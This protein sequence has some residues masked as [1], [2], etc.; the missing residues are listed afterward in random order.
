MNTLQQ[1]VKQ[2]P[3]NVI[4]TS[5]Y[6]PRQCGLATY[7]K[8]LTNA[9]NLLNSHSLAEILTV[10]PSGEN[11][12][13]PWESKFKINHLD[14][15]D[16]VG[17]AEYVNRSHADLVSLQHEFGLF[18]GDYGEY[19]VY[20]AEA[21]KIPLVT[22]FHTVLGEPSEK[23]REIIQR[24]AKK[25]Q[26]IIVMMEQV[27]QKLVSIYKVPRE[28][29]VV[30]PHGVPDIPFNATSMQ[31]RKHKLADRIVLGNINLLDP[32]K[33]IEYALE[34][35]ALLAKKYSNVLYMVIGQ[36]H[37]DLIKKED[38]N[39]R[40]F[41]KKR[42]RELG[43]SH[44][45]RFINKYLSL[46][47]LINWLKVIDVYITPYLEPQQATSGA[48][49]YAIGAGRACV[50]TPY[51]YAKEVLEEGRGVLVPF[52]D[53]ESI[54]NAVT[55]LLEHPDKSKEMATRAYKFGR[56]M[57]WPNVAQSHL[58]L[59]HTILRKNDRPKKII[60]PYTLSGSLLPSGQ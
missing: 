25:S 44:N 13:Y 53:S 28:K 16:Y 6:I 30:I 47:E 50:S 35:V 56:L 43:I 14:L 2:E 27:A 57:T 42:V 58:T 17:A 5:S 46:A 3:I 45:V 7:T 8:D 49:A 18:G 15:P 39:Y 51:I 32:N 11:I 29:I 60:A 21:L 4:Y 9:I 26:A 37:P 40:K 54:A 41:L 24:L 38:E 1:I 10:T 34:A 12:D 23:Q 52:R 20:F 31:K 19:I 59:F 22:T 55:D 48:L 36:T 33:G